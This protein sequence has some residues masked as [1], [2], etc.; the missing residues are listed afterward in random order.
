[1]RTFQGFWAQYG[2]HLVSSLLLCL[3]SNKG[4]KTMITRYYCMVLA[5]VLVLIGAE[6]RL[7]FPERYAENIDL[8]P[9]IEQGLPLDAFRSEDL[10]RFFEAF[11]DHQ[12][13]LVF[14]TLTDEQKRFGVN[15]SYPEFNTEVFGADVNQIDDQVEEGNDDEEEYVGDSVAPSTFRK[16]PSL[17]EFDPQVATLALKDAMENERIYDIYFTTIVGVVSGLTVFLIVGAGFLFHR[18]RKN[19]KAAEEVEYPAYG[20]TGPGKDISPTSGDRKLAQNAQLY[21]YQHQKQQMIAFDNNSTKTNGAVSD[22]ESEDGEEGDYTV[23]EC[24]G[25]APTGEMEVR[26]PMFEDETT[27]KADAATK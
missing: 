16:R 26:N 13:Q 11:G 25:L 18:A 8:S 7:E 14:P 6:A 2:R 3:P 5:V 21:H 24:P 9:I 17:G 1:M 20:V 12:N 10:A 23:Y 27:P 19:A 15:P 4:P 22:N